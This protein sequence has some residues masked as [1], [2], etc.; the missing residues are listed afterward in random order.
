MA[1]FHGVFVIVLFAALLITG[2]VIFSMTLSSTTSVSAVESNIGVYWDSNCIKMVDE[3]KWGIL[4]PRSLKTITVYVR[5]E[6]EPLFLFMSTKNWDPYTASKYIELGWD[7]PVG[8]RLNSG[9]VLPI[10]LTLSI[11]PYIKGISD[12]SFDIVITG[13][14]RLPGDVNGDDKVNILDLSSIVTIMSEGIYDP[15]FDLDLSGPPI[16]ILDVAAVATAMAYYA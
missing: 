9:E 14:Q 2:I 15:F 6:N 16:N 1:R 11:S 13:S 3:I 5:N 4:E 10:V 12:F 8:L 7:W